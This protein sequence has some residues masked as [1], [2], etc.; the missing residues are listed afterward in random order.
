MKQLIN[1]RACFRACLYL[2]F[3][4]CSFSLV[5]QKAVK[6]L[7]KK[8]EKLNNELNLTSQLLKEIASK[9]TN[10]VN[11]LRILEEQ[12]ETREELVKTLNEQLVLVEKKIDGLQEEVKVKEKSLD[13]EKEEYAEMIRYAYKSRSNNNM[14]IFL[15]SADS[16]NDAYRR[17]R[18]IKEYNDY[19]VTQVNLIAAQKDTLDNKI[20]ELHDER[21]QKTQ[22]VE[23]TAQEKNK[24]LAEK[25]LKSAIVNE[26]ESK[27]SEL[28]IEVEVKQIA[29]NSLESEITSIIEAEIKKQKAKEKAARK[30]REKK[31]RAAT[32]KTSKTTAKAPPKITKTPESVTLS[33]NFASNKGKLPWPVSQGVITGKF[34]KSQHKVKGIS[35][36]NTGIDISTKKNSEVRAVFD[37]EVTTIIYSPVFQNAIIVKHGDYFSVYSNVKD[38]QVSKGDKIKTKDV[39]GSVSSNDGKTEVHF[40]IWKATTKMNP[41]LWIAKK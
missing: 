29:I 28:A 14:L 22:I 11:E 23:E 24:L 37:G 2:L 15:M 17:L 13:A 10:S 27:E 20:K 4:F 31:E 8:K 35:V 16:F 36:N 25:K 7:E 40:E 26:L 32:K 33:N 30:A 5:A 9:K 6:T 3:I 39:L 19:R 1:T 38:V 21:G 34:G 12:V 18:Y 41:V